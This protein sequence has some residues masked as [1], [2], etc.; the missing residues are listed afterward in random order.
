MYEISLAIALVAF[1]AV[2][3]AYSRSLVFSIYHPLTYY[4]LFHGF[5]FVFRPII[6]YLS[7]FQLVY[8]AYQFIPSRSDKVTVILAATVGFLCFSFF[9]IRTGGTRMVFK[10]DA[11]LEIERDYVAK[12]LIWVVVLL[13]PLGLYS[14]LARYQQSVDGYS[15]MVIDK[16]NGVFINTVSNGYVTD[17]QMMLATLGAM[18]AWIFR[19]RFIS[20]IPLFSF[21]LIRA[22]T[23]GRGPF[24][25]ACISL[26]LLW[27]YQKRQSMISPRVL[28]AFLALIAVFDQVGSD[29][30]AA[31]R[32]L[33]NGDKAAQRADDQEKWLEGMDFA[34]MEY[35]EFIVYAI[36]QRSN[37]Y[38]Y[39]L[40][41]LQIVTEP[42]PRVWWPGKPA[43]APFSNI[44]LFDYGYPIGMTRSLPGEG[45]YSLGWVG[46]VIWCSLW[47][48]VLG[49]IYRRWVKSDQSTLKTLAYLLF[50]PSLVVSYRDGTLL[51]AARQ[52]L[53]FL[54]PIVLA[55]LLARWIGVPRLSEIRTYLEA[56]GLT[57]KAAS[58]S[59]TGV[60]NRAQA[61][62]VPLPVL[63]RRTALAAMEKER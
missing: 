46:V 45:W 5:I 21:V 33:I 56:K 14:L 10:N 26:G 31:V 40:N 13:S 37:E 25:T 61:I 42:I 4:C 2:V 9:C 57:Q 3:V 7:D 17:A 1:L 28:I 38:G 18:V 8:A 39:F 52:N 29:R 19:F 30:G 41:N 50:I 20:L 32:A 44:A 35:F 62:P 23:G 51:T 12:V 60:R 24:V 53:W 22:G 49:W 59:L 11:A 43:G 16:A 63:R 47:G 55:A 15:S 34:N 48:A 36:P 58:L 6:A 27:L 54:G